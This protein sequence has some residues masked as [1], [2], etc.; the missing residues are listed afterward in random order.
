MADLEFG[1]N[2]FAQNERCTRILIKLAGGYAA[3][4]SKDVREVLEN[5]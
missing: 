3:P 2:L 4:S 1:R 5:I